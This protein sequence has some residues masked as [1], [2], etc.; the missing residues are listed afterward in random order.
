MTEEQLKYPIGKFEKPELITRDILSKW[1]LEISDFPARLKNEVTYLTDEQLDTQYRPGGWTIRQVV[2]HCADSHM[3]SF[4]R[5]KL[6]LTEEKPT[7][8]PFLEDRWAALSDG[9]TAPIEPSL[10][11]LEGLHNRWVS[12]LN[13]LT[14]E[15]LHK[16]FIH[17]EQGREFILNEN[18]GIYAWHGNHH[19]AHITQLKK[20]KKWK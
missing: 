1:I 9:K 18:I 13:S 14:E 3:T 11:V 2:H 15:D 12:L 6:A 17:P 10:M 16:K 7:I 20:I 4:T 19:L 5:F 8:K